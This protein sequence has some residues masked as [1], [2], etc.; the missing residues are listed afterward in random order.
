MKHFTFNKKNFLNA[1]KKVTPEQRLEN[2]NEEEAN[3]R[4][5]IIATNGN[6]GKHYVKTNKPTPELK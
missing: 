1:M 4:I 3:K 2:H 5:D 6:T